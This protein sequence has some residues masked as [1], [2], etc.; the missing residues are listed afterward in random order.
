MY[1]GNNITSLGSDIDANEG[2]ECSWKAIDH[3]EI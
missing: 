3:I 2:V 1:L